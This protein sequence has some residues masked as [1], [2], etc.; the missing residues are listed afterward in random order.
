MSNYEIIEPYAFTPSSDG[1]GEEFLANSMRG[2]RLSR[3]ASSLYIQFDLGEAKEVDR[4]ALLQTNLGP[5]STWR[6]RADDDSNVTS[7]PLYD[8]NALSFPMQGTHRGGFYHGVHEVETDTAYRYWRVDVTRSGGSPI[9]IPFAVIG[10]AHLFTRNYDR[11]TRP[12]FREN[13][14]QTVGDYGDEVREGGVRKADLDLILSF[15]HNEAYNM[16]E[17]VFGSIGA[18]RPVLIRLQPGNAT[19]DA[20]K[21]YYAFFPP[22][23]SLDRPQFF[24][25]N[26][27]AMRMRGVI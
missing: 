12:I 5:G 14:L 7:G 10:K 20:A 16:F 23:L 17:Q 3:S 1:S 11:G 26:T 27:V 19:Y 22:E 4:I 6:I 25:K 8:R 21:T 13:V 9:T 24:D 15:T 2:Q 18:A